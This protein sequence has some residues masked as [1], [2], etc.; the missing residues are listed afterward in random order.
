MRFSVIVPVYGVEKYL[1]E[2]VAS[3]LNQT[4]TDFEIILVDDKSPDNCPEM[5]D[6]YAKS[7]SRIRVIHKPQNEGLG[8]ARNTGLEAAKGDYIIFADSDDT[9]EPQWL[10]RCNTE[11]AENKPDILA[12]GV[13]FRYEDKNGAVKKTDTLIPDPF[14]AVTPTE[15]GE[16]FAL[17]NRCR[18][19]QYAWNK[20]YRREFLIS[21]GV[22][23][24]RTPLIEDFL[25]NIAVLT[26]ATSVKSVNAAYYNYRKPQHETLASRYS[27]EFFELCKRKYLLEK[28]FL[29][30]CDCDTLYRSLICE[31]FIK[32][33][34]STV[35]RNRSKS[36][37]LKRSQQ[38]QLIKQMCCDPITTEV[39]T[40]YRST[41]FV[42]KVLCNS[43]K[44]CQVS[45]LLLI[46]SAIGFLKQ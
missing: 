3:L 41:S 37:S 43:I 9:V 8:F 44:K 13:N 23:F 33:F 11:I 25:F 40:L 12:F 7:D 16:L 19:F 46:C 27:P 18:V 5:C 10:E 45:G 39:V 17:L 1:D 31:S 15:K 36:A 35:L 4:Y 24:E 32:H 21:I 20:A 22:L 6:G 38:K 14:Y 26:R 2:C 42:Y 28:Q 34:V 29:A 30:D